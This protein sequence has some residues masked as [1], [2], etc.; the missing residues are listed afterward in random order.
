MKAYLLLIGVVIAGVVIGT[1]HASAEATFTLTSGS[2]SVKVDPHSPAGT[3][4]WLL[5]GANHL[6]RQWFWFRVNGEDTAEKSVD[7]LS[8]TSASQPSSDKATVFYDSSGG[9]SPAFQIDFSFTLTGGAGDTADLLEDITIRNLS[10]TQT[11]N[12]TFFQYADFDLNGL[13]AEALDDSVTVPV[14]SDSDKPDFVNTATQ[15]DTGSITLS[16]TVTGGSGNPDRFEVG[17][18]ATILGKLTDGDVDDLLYDATDGTQI[19][20]GGGVTDVAWAFQWDLE[21]A[22]NG[23]S[24]IGK[25]KILQVPEPASIAL[26]L[27]GAL[28][29]MPG[30]RRRQGA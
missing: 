12:I 25:D 22:P 5:G 15:T 7:T 23:V 13:T 29:A 11:L 28:V 6:D 14:Q 3:Y 4:D 2:S 19:A 9:Y 16:E 10:D 18:A 17:A 30:L 21:I 24:S 8:I 27:A 1:F 20:V 26:V